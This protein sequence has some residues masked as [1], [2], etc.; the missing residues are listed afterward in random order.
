MRSLMSNL[1]DKSWPWVGT[2]RCTNSKWVEPFSNPLFLP[3]LHSSPSISQPWHEYKWR[4]VRSRDRVS[5][6]GFLLSLWQQHTLMGSAWL[7][8]IMSPDTL[9]RGCKLSISLPPSPRSSSSLAAVFILFPMIILPSFT[10][11]LRLIP[12][13]YSFLRISFVPCFPFRFFLISLNN[14]NF[15]KFC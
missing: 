9:W 2:L 1:I 14:L 15:L 11:L 3:P 8:S 10:L 7:D 6:N 12:S 4:L 13:S 5:V